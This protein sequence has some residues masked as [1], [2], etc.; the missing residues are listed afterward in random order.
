M[1]QRDWKGPLIKLDEY[2]WEIPRS[3]KPAMR[4][5]GIIYADEG[6]IG[7][8]VKDFAPEQV[9]NV[10]TM[11][12][13]VG[14]AQAMPDIHWGYGM[15]VGG[16]AAFDADGGVISPGSVG[17][18]I[19][20]GVR[21]L[22][23][24][25]T[26][27]EVRPKLKELVDTMFHNVPSGVGSH[28]RIRVDAKEVRTLT[29]EGLRWALDQGY[30]WAEDERRVESQG[31]LPAADS[32]KVSDMAVKR[33]I[34]QLGSLGAGNH[35]LEIQRVAEIYDPKSAEA[36]GL[37]LDQ[38][39]VLIHSG[40]RG[41]GH[42]VATD[43]IRVAE[44]STRDHN[45]VL[46]DRQLA[47]MPLHSREGEDYFAAM[48]AAA[49]FGWNNRQLITH[50]V[51]QSFEKVLGRS[52]EDLGLDIVYDVGH[53]TA[54][55]EEHQVDGRR[56]KVYVHR[57]GAT[58]AFPAGHPEVPQAYRAVGQPVLIP[59]SMGNYSFVLVGL[60][61]A[62]EKSFGSTCHGAGR[63]MSRTEATRRYRAPQVVQD[64]AEQGI[65]LHAASREGIVEEAPGAY[66]DADRVVRVCQ[67]AG[68]SK[69]VAKLVPMGVVKG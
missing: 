12:G 39:T 50:W 26:E 40:S 25:L 44:Q 24:N 16:V 61:G 7:D 31:R 1:A 60:P 20:C 62:M 66:K 58:R 9:A 41:F 49:N 56:V 43:Y 64:L 47:C 53:N 32:S 35:F 30:G 69:I 13:I 28:G 2:R 38:M 21:L 52:A 34:P 3:Y 48:S 14:E 11:P 8:I 33:G 54:K 67:G 10:A 6:L 68:L 63:V 4:T 51:R 65:Y 59:G 42:Q 17:Y 45:I 55:P 29:E 46:P 18:D 37:S 5:R 23:S 27:Q 19:N 36:L 22:R 15:P 57:K